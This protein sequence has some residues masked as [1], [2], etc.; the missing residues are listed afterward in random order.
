M[1][2]RQFAFGLAG[3]TWIALI[4]A[5]ALSIFGIQSFLHYQATPFPFFG[6]GFIMSDP[7]IGYTGMPNA[8]MHHVVP[9]VY[10]VFTNHRGGRDSYLGQQAPENIDFLFVGDS[11]TWGGGVSDEETF[12]KTLGRRL[13]ASVFNAAEPNYSMVPALLSIE[14]FADMKPRYIV[15]GF[16]AEALPGI[17]LPC[18]HKTALLCRPMAYLDRGPIGLE[19]RPPGDGQLYSSYVRDIVFHHSFGWRDIYWTAY[20]DISLTISNRT[21]IAREGHREA[22]SDWRSDPAW[23]VLGLRLLV[24][25]MVKKASSLGARLIFLNI[26]P[27]WVSGA[28]Y[29]PPREVME[30][31]EEERNSGRLL[32]VDCVPLLREAAAAHGIDHV[33]IP[34]DGHFTAAAHAIVAD[35][36]AAVVITQ[37]AQR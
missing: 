2:R 3:G 30:A 32:Y 24:D 20:R 14:K 17:F 27:S 1:T 26:S 12:V 21:R 29:T 9:P 4:A 34:G 25:E 23:H 33:R 8:E 22:D 16:L 15:F 13:G 28:D 37:G 10:D 36:I 19:M 31:L 7:V 5:T 11:Y 6:T 35:E 18:A